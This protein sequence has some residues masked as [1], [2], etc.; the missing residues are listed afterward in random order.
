MNGSSLL[1]YKVPRVRVREGGKDLTLTTNKA[2]KVVIKLF[3]SLTSKLSRVT[4]L[5]IGVWF[6]MGFRV[7]LY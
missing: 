1:L 7:V 4:I 3:N 2:I 5:F 6:K